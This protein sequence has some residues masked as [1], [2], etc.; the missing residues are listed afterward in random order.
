MQI[1]KKKFNRFTKYKQKHKIGLITNGAPDLQWKKI[2][3]GNLQ[4][5]F[6]SIIISGE[7]GFG[8]PDIRLF[9]KALEGLD[10]D[11]SATV[12]VGDSMRSDIQG[13]KQAGI[14]SVWINRENKKITDETIIPDYKIASLSELYDIV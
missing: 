10:C 1:P 14:K 5:Y 12:M 13:A 7:H 9:H 11:E 8:K 3:G 6:D 2:I 4:P